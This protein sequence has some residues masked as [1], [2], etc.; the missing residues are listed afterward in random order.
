MDRR[1]D[2]TRLQV[3]PL[4]R[5][6]VN[7]APRRWRRLSDPAKY[8]LYTR[9][10]L[11]AV[12]LALGVVGV[13]QTGD[14]AA[15]VL[16]FLA[17]FAG[18]AFLQVR[19]ELTGIER[20]VHGRRIQVACAAAV[21]VAWVGGLI[22]IRAGDHR[23]V[24]TVGMIT[25]VTMALAMLPFF[26]YHWIALLAIS[27]ATIV[28]YG[29]DRNPLL[30]IAILT[31]I[32][33]F[34]VVTTR[35]SLWTL[36]IVD[37]LDNARRTEAQLKVAEERLRFA[38]DLHDVVGRSFSAIAVKS[39]LASRLARTPGNADRAAVEMDQ[40]K[41]LAVESMEEMRSLVRSYRSID[42]PVEVAGAKSLLEAAGCHLTIEGSP[43]AVP[44]QFHEA[45]A[46]VVREGT[47]NIVRHSSGTTAALTLGVTGL[48]LSNNGAAASA[49][50]RS[51]LAGLA[52]RLRAVGGT[53]DADSTGGV[54]T[55]R[56]RWEDA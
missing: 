29:Y 6:R 53:L 23:M 42:L 33:A 40:V 38:R 3:L 39:E 2:R 27:V 41:T 45:A 16:S 21:A 12:L 47:T 25:V 30:G 13:V 1:R 15:G 9:V 22:L 4:G 5:S 37:D 28:G 34:M 32:G 56:V 49:G 44:A 48:T 50:D 35:A 7:L 20:P 31:A 11:Q 19:P 46:W 17:L 14:V 18:V 8:R 24:G 26:R 51:G 36:R 54:F 10:T 43:E 52:E 55:L